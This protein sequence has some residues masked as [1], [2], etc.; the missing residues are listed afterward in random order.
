MADALPTANFKHIEFERKNRN[1]RYVTVYLD[2]GDMQM[3]AI[4]QEQL[5]TSR[6][7]VVRAS[8]HAYAQ[9]VATIMKKS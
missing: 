7:A 5:G 9:V 8:I 3:L 6:S 1:D 2:P 4:M